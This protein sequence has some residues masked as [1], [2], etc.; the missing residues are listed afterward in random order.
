MR[1]SLTPRYLMWWNIQGPSYFTHNSWEFSHLIFEKKIGK[2]RVTLIVHCDTF[3]S[4]ILFDGFITVLV[5][6][7]TTL[8]VLLILFF[9]Y[10]EWHRPIAIVW[11]QC[12]PSFFIIFHLFH[13]FFILG[14]AAR[15]INKNLLFEKATSRMTLFALSFQFEIKA[16]VMNYP[17]KRLEIRAFVEK[18][19]EKINWKGFQFRNIV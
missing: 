2:I 4:T 17:N 5:H 8:T 18:V 6:F 7:Y 15:T 13:F 12:D 3:R 16:H 11:C 10:S 1:N 19:M 9:H 14:Q